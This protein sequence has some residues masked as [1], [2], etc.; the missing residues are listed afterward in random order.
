MLQQVHGLPRSGRRDQ[1]VGQGQ[2]RRRRGGRR[3][4]HRGGTQE[5]LRIGR[6]PGF[7]RQ[8]PRKQ[9]QLRSTVLG[10]ELRRHPLEP[11]NCPDRVTLL[12]L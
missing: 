3:L 9:P 10:S 12:Q 11:G 8:T 5:P 2:L 1:Q 7:S 6:F 4:F